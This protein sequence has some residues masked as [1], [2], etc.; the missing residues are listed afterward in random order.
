MVKNLWQQAPK[1]ANSLLNMKQQLTILSLP[2]HQMVAEGQLQ[3]KELLAAVSI[4]HSV[5]IKCVLE[6]SS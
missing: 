3:S 6:E 2:L 5:L 4:F 1:L